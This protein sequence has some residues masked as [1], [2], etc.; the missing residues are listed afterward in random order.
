M[1]SRH[2]LK[3]E[4]LVMQQYFND[5][6]TGIN[7]GLSLRSNGTS[8]GG[9]NDQFSDSWD[10]V[11]I[12]NVS[13]T[14]NGSF[15]NTDGNDNI[16]IIEATGYDFDSVTGEFVSDDGINVTWGEYTIEQEQDCQQIPSTSGYSDNPFGT[17]NES[18]G[19]SGDPFWST[20]TNTWT[21]CKEYY[22]KRMNKEVGSP[23]SDEA[24]REMIYNNCGGCLKAMQVSDAYLKLW[25]DNYNNP[26]IACHLCNDSAGDLFLGGSVL[27]AW[28]QLTFVCGDVDKDKLLNEILPDCE[29]GKSGGTKLTWAQFAEKVKGKPWRAKNGFYTT[30]SAEFGDMAK[31]FGMSGAELTKLSDEDMCNKLNI[32]ACLKPAAAGTI[33]AINNSEKAA[34]LDFYKNTDLVNPCSG[35]AIDKDAIFMSLC[36]KDEVSMSGLDEALDGVDKIIPDESF[37][38]CSH[39][40]CVYNAIAKQ[41]NSLWCNTTANFDNFESTD[42][43]LQLDGG[44]N[45]I[46]SNYFV[47]NPKSKGVTGLNGN[48][49]VVIA[50]NPSLCDSDQPLLIANTILHE[51]IHAEIW[52]YMKEN[53]TLGDWPDNVNTTT[54]EETFKKLFELCCTSGVLNNQHN[55]MLEQWIDQL[56]KGLWEFNVKQGNWED[57]KYLAIQGI[58]D[59]ND[60]CS[61][62]LISEL[63]YE[64]L[65]ADFLKIPNYFT[66]DKCD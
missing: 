7:N 25:K 28:D 60:D 39:L 42:L 10:C 52:R 19:S 34:L 62:N 50:F 43:V 64:K 53:W 41:N 29:I 56:S 26:K 8:G 24:M 58:W 9:N 36:E 17:S 13:T 47:T 49:Q 27:Q 51:G 44:K 5:K 32:A 40:K 14:I 33:E 1:S 21:K 20:Q 45:N 46:P 35:E 57:Y 30:Y 61:K 38:N 31:L 3:D 37:K 63:E 59:K 15:Y 6:L 23:V 66:F 55:L 54:S 4:F 11:E 16:I 22:Q 65:R 48:G 2:T 12:V 18:G